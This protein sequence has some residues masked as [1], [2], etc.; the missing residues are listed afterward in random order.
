LLLE[1]V[2]LASKADMSVEY[3]SIYDSLRDCLRDGLK[4]L[5]KGNDEARTMLMKSWE[6][7]RVSGLK[8][9]SIQKGRKKQGCH[10]SKSK[11]LTMIETWEANR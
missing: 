2:D 11:F 9:K 4:K 7:A 8:T 6:A 1:S 5:V 3:N 10:T